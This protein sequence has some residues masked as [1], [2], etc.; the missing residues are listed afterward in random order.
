MAQSL[1]RRARTHT[2][3]IGDDH[4]DRYETAMMAGVVD[5]EM[6]I[7][8]KEIL[9][10]LRAALD[11][12]ARQVWQELSGKPLGAAIYFPIAREGA[13]SSD[14]PAL[15]NARMPGVLAASPEAVQE[16]ASMQEFSEQTNVW[17]PE[18]AT[19]ANQAKHEHLHVA[20]IPAALIRMKKDNE[21]RSSLSFQDG[22]HLKRGFPWMMLHPHGTPSETET[23]Y[24]AR[25]LVLTEID[26]ELASFLKAALAGVEN[27]ISRCRSLVAATPL[28][29]SESGE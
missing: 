7:V 18:L 3:W 16:L 15:M 22:Y 28:L 11:Y 2:E 6:Q 17:L 24:E 10:H 13:K 4:G 19:L 25:F 20:T 8:T 21:G 14:F 9:D 12:C 23:T 26:V 1:V 27:I 29:E 5:E